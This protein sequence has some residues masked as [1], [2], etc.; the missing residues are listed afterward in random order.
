MAKVLP[1]DH[2]CH[3]CGIQ[4]AAT[5]YYSNGYCRPCGA[6]YYADWRRKNY[7][8]AKAHHRA[9]YQRHKEKCKAEARAYGRKLK[10]EALAAYG[11]HCDCCGEDRH[12]FLAIDHINGGG[13]KHRAE[14]GVGIGAGFF[15]WLRNQNYPSDFRVLCHNCNFAFGNFGYCPHVEGTHPLRTRTRE[16]RDAKLLPLV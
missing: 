12:E 2:K 14:I 13:K 6:A 4:D 7:E 1:P 16:E 8:K 10:L 3:R 11:G 5:G 9:Y 15:R